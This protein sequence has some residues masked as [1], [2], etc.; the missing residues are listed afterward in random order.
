MVS[1]LNKVQFLMPGQ[2]SG[3]W[4]G[5]FIVTGGA[6]GA[7][8]TWDMKTIHTADIYYTICAR[9]GTSGYLDYS[10]N[11]SDW[12]TLKGITDSGITSSGTITARYIRHRYSSD[13]SGWSLMNLIAIIKS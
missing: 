2:S 3:S 9:S 11:N 13:G 12:S 4:A 8:Y 5:G 6:Y 7:S 1:P 10:T